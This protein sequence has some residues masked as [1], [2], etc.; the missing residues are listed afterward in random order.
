MARWTGWLGSGERGRGGRP[1]R[2]GRTSRGAPVYGDLL[3]PTTPMASEWQLSGSPP[4]AGPSDAQQASGLV[5]HARR[6]G[7]VA[8]MPQPDSAA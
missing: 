3:A 1:W 6:V 5:I 7:E 4:E 2:E 8:A